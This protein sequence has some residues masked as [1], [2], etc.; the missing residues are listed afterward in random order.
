MIQAN[1][2]SRFTA[3]DFD[4]VVK[5]LGKSSQDAGCLTA[6]LTDEDSR[7][8]ILDDDTLVRAV[9]DET[10]H[11]S[12]SPQFYFYILTS[13]VLKCSGCSRLVCDYIASLLETFSRAAALHGPAQLEQS[14]EI[15]L[16]DMLLALQKATPVQAFMIRSH[17]ANHSLFMSGIFHE[18]VQRRHQ[19]GA[20]PVSFYEE[21]GRSNY[22]VASGDRVAR[23]W[24]LAEVMAMLA[25]RFREIRL[26]LNRLAD[27]IFNF[28][29]EFAC[30]GI[31]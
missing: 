2:R 11:L 10:G 23:Q 5:S 21:M 28:G 27:N 9:L 24:D 17:I 14:G 4:F 13:H 15:Y 3:C 6:L 7:D 29:D 8:A 20:P 12:I 16:S 1:C 22:L 19:R 30:R 26:A 25:E 31:I 18:N